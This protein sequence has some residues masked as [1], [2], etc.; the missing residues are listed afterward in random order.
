MIKHF[1]YFDA[2]FKYIMWELIITCGVESI[3]TREHGPCHN[4]VFLRK[5]MEGETTLKNAYATLVKRLECGGYNIE[6]K[7]S[8]ESIFNYVRNKS[9]LTIKGNPTHIIFSVDCLN[10]ELQDYLAE[11]R[12]PRFEFYHSENLKFLLEKLAGE[13]Q[14]NLIGFLS[15]C[16]TNYFSRILELTNKAT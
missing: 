6:A 15:V 7:E 8:L 5:G 16:N 10:I 9:S 2:Y 14:K 12:L 3:Y 4:E 1:D 11:E 13:Y